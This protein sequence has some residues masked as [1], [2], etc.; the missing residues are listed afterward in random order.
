[1]DSDDG[2]GWLMSKGAEEYTILWKDG[3]KLSGRELGREL[4][5]K[6][7]ET[8]FI[9]SIWGRATSSSDDP[10]FFY[11]PYTWNMLIGVIRAKLWV[12]S[13]TKYPPP[14][15]FIYLLYLFIFL[16]LECPF[17]L[18]TLLDSSLIIC[19]MSWLELTLSKLSL[20]KTIQNVYW[21]KV[22]SCFAMT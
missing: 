17:L 4:K 14:H 7:W 19:L 21:D 5:R 6:T 8:W 3:W 2:W 20:Y 11:S 13:V 10:L 12:K 1:M 15:S 16:C 9:Y 22:I 18:F